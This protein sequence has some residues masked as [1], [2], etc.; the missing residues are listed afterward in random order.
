MMKVTINNRV[1][2]T[3]LQLKDVA[4][5]W[6]D[7]PSGYA[8]Q[9]ELPRKAYPRNANSHNA[10]VVLLVPKHKALVATKINVGA[11]A[12][13]VQEF[14]HMNPP[15]FLGS[16]V[17]QDRRTSLTSGKKIGVRMQFLS[18][19]NVSG[20]NYLLVMHFRSSLLDKL[21]QTMQMTTMLMQF[22]QFQTISSLGL[23]LRPYESTRIS[24]VTGWRRPQNFIDEVNKIFGMMKVTIN[25]RVEFMSYPL[26][27]V[28]HI[29]YDLPSS[30]AFQVKPRRNTYPRNANA[31]NA[32][33]IPPFPDH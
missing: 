28:A 7:L 14:V 33:A 17:G 11:P 32:N 20:M 26:K 2:F 30:Y 3:S 23:R 6:Y 8:F 12:A 24:R 29:W 15:E 27:D 19:G 22:L 25:D 5:I 9:I 1:E 31:Q 21:I 13:R 4:H 16:Q 18:L 10:N